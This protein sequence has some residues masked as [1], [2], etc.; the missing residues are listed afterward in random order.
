MMFSDN[1]AMLCH[2]S[3][4]VVTLGMVSC[5]AKAFDFRQRFFFETAWKSAFEVLL[6]NSRELL[7]L[8]ESAGTPQRLPKSH[9]GWSLHEP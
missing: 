6:L 2:Q 3:M 4:S 1:I 5:P 7:Q 9:S 8:L